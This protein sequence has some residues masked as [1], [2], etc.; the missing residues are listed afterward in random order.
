[1][2][3]NKACIGLRIM[4]CPH[5]LDIKRPKREKTV[6]GVSNDPLGLCPAPLLH[7]ASSSTH[8][9]CRYAQCLSPSLVIH[10]S[11]NARSYRLSKCLTG[12]P[13]K[14]VYLPTTEPHQTP[15]SLLN[16][17]HSRSSAAR[18]VGDDTTNKDELHRKRAES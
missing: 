7:S 14:W 11:H 16:P 5:S 1:M 6:Q 12:E 4:S 10:D 18:I 8:R 15:C 3:P 13:Y 2:L 9:S 17:P